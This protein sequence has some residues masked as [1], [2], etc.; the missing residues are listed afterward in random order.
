M[1]VKIGDIDLRTYNKICDEYRKDST[2]LGCTN[3]D[4]ERCPFSKPNLFVCTAVRRE[5]C[6]EE[7]EV[8][9]KFLDNREREE[10]LRKYA[11]TIGTHWNSQQGPDG[12]RLQ[13]E[14][15]NKQ[16]YKYMEKAAQT[17]IDMASANRKENKND[18][19]DIG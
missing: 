19:N 17:C 11:A 7:V 4:G 2:K 6:E 14:T 10:I 1:K 18:S 13:F 3:S 15:D 12:C 16:L 8:P 5:F 9:D